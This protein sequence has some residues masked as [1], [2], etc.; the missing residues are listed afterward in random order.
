MSKLIYHPQKFYQS[1]IN[2][3]VEDLNKG[4][5]G[6]GKR[7]HKTNHEESKKEDYDRLKS[8]GYSDSEIKAIWERDRIDQRP[9]PG[10][11]HYRKPQEDRFES[12]KYKARPYNRDADKEYSEPQK[13]RDAR[14]GIKREE[15]SR[16]ES[17]KMADTRRG[18]P[19]FKRD[20]K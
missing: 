2:D 1:D 11:V 7:G 4:G 19:G 8:K 3:M 10:S 9:T 12:S 17:Q 20:R 18:G 5:V 15:D 13:M 6:S 14:R 16:T